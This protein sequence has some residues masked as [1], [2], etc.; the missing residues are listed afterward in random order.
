MAEHSIKLESKIALKQSDFDV[1]KAEVDSLTERHA[2]LGKELE[3]KRY[4]LIKMQHRLA[5]LNEI[6][7][8]EKAK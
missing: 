4:R 7:E 6:L 3:T 8:E 1:L 2:A 5:A